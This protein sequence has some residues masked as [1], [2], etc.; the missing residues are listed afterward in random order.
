MQ[1]HFYR[2]IAA[3]AAAAIT[4]AQLTAS[5]QV[6]SAKKEKEP[7]MQTSETSALDEVAA[8]AA[9]GEKNDAVY[10]S[11]GVIDPTEPDSDEPDSSADLIIVTAE[12]ISS[13]Q[14]AEE[15]SADLSETSETEAP[16]EEPT[17]APTEEPTETLTEE[18]TE[19]PTEVPTEAP[20]ADPAPTEAV[21]EEP[22]E[23]VTDVPA[24]VA[25]HELGTPTKNDFSYLG[26]VG[27]LSAAQTKEVA[28]LIYNAISSHE[29]KIDFR[30]LKEKMYRSKD[31]DSLTAVFNTVVYSCREGVLTNQ[32]YRY[33]TDSNT[34]QILNMTI[35]YRL[36]DMLYDDAM[37]LANEKIDALLAQ[38]Q[39]DWSA[40]EIALFFHDYMAVHYNY[41]YETLREYEEMEAMPDAGA[42]C[43]TAYGLLE[44]KVAVCQGYAWLYNILLN[45]CG[46][47]CY[48]VTSDENAHAWNAIMLDGVCY[49]VDV[50]W[51]DSAQLRTS[52][53]GLDGQVDHSSFL[54]NVAGMIGSGHKFNER[55]WVLSTGQP[56]DELP[57]SNDYSNHFLSGT[58]C[59]IYPYQEGWLVKTPDPENHRAASYVLYDYDFENNEDIWVRQVASEADRWYCDLEKTRYYSDNYSVCAVEDDIV[60]Y[61]TNSGV[62][63]VAHREGGGTYDYVWEWLFGLDEEEAQNGF[64]YGMRIEGDKMYYQVIPSLTSTPVEYCRD[65]EPFREQIRIASGAPAG[66]LDGDF[67]LTVTD[68]VTMYQH[69]IGKTEIESETAKK[70]ADLVED[71]V[72]DVFDLTMLK[73]LVTTQQSPILSS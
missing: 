3:A 62:L 15:E 9:G 71:G 50:T 55:D 43:Y 39:P 13:E 16:T 32:G 67:T 20:T 1:K 7:V 25:E 42:A 2:L 26:A 21:S 37:T 47:E 18:P 35:S 40:P 68:V 41:D 72:L 64:I 10:A 31:I 60:Y 61:T 58:R 19:A 14:Q 38:V 24:D 27:S 45:E 4:V 48:M 65:M 28:D 36:P 57:F 29:T 53:T 49:Q 51:D 63:A 23:A 22:T 54:N 30:D 56:V 52:Q 44:E 69:I 33:Y 70:R 59:A 11:E 6:A 5:A 46:V 73:R 8:E 17:E 12:L 34:E 66:D